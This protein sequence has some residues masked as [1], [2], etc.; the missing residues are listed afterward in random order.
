MKNI[1]IPVRAFLATVFAATATLASST[2]ATAQSSSGFTSFIRQVQ[3]DSG[4]VRDVSV[5]ETGQQLSDLAMDTTGARFELWT[6]KSSPLTSYLLDTKYVGSYVP[7]AEVNVFSEDPYDEIPRT[8]AD[9]PFYFNIQLTGL[10]HGASDPPASKAVKFY[11]HVQE[12]GVNGN[13]IGIDR[14][15]ANKIWD[16]TVN[17]DINGT[18]TVALT[19]IP[20]ADRSK[21]RGEER[22]SFF[23]IPDYQAP[24][25]QLASKYIQIWPVADATITGLTPN[26]VIKLAAPELSITLNDLY[27]DSETFTQVYKGGPQLGTQ[28]TVIPGSALVINDSVPHDRTLIVDD[29]D[30]VFTSD[31][32]WTMEVLTTTPF[33][34]DRLTYF[35]FNVDRK[36]RINGQ[37]TTTE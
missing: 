26:Q 10:L 20:G 2:T 33:G 32:Q 30:E 18:G 37:V 17:F 28:G 29:Y 11:R 9:R 19:A 35:S 21:V 36:L 1:N 13:G 22:F 31:G 6:V 3:M 14:T 16:F 23:T 27:P 24:S 4:L 25:T 5:A 8:R 12:Y 34:T 7:G 15:Q